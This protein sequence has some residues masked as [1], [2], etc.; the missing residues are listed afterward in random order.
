M[1]VSICTPLREVTVHFHARIRAKSCTSIRVSILYAPGRRRMAGQ[2]LRNGGSEI[3]VT[4]VGED[5][6]GLR[7]GEVSEGSNTTP[8]HGVYDAEAALG[9]LVESSSEHGEIP[10]QRALRAIEGRTYGEG[11]AA[12]PHQILGGIVVCAEIGLP[13]AGYP[14]PMSLQKLDR[15]RHGGLICSGEEGSWSRSWRWRQ[16]WMWVRCSHHR[17]RSV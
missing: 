16:P 6:V 3:R 12:L 8:G 10:P 13:T 15:S 5:E 2:I 9:S 17:R 4:V 7:L 1:L 11:D 14:L